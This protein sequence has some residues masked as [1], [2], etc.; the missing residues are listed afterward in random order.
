MQ[1]NNNWKYIMSMSY[2]TGDCRKLC[3]C[4]EFASGVFFGEHPSVIPVA[5]YSVCMCRC[6]SEVGVLAAATAS[7]TGFRNLYISYV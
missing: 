6:V 3:G 1:Y 4:C 2:Y 5:A 7:R